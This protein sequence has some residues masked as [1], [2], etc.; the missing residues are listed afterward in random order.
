MAKK[1]FKYKGKAL[2]ELKQMSIKEL[3]ALFDASA[4]RKIKRG[5]TNAEKTLLENVDKKDFLKTHCRDMLI[6]PAMVGKTIGVYNG[7][8]F[9]SVQVKEEMLGKRLGEFSMTRRPIKHS[10]PGIGSSKSTLHQTAGGG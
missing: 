9:T 1:I 6:L 8:E 4:R 5:F 7:K 10:A 3:S 2:E